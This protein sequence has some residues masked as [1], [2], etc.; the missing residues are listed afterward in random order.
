MTGRA[1]LSTNWRVKSETPAPSPTTNYRGKGWGS[2]QEGREDRRQSTPSN[3]VK[4]DPLAVQAMEE[5]RRLYVGNMPYMAKKEDV[6]SLFRDGDYK[7]QVSNG[8]LTTLH[9]NSRPNETGTAS[10]SQLTPSLAETPPTAS[11]S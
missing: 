4:D 7:V 3:N 6:E 5:G 10:S 2:K 9:A 1:D 11:S 8:L